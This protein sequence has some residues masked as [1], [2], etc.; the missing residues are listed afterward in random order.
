MLG[1]I[2]LHYDYFSVDTDIMQGVMRVLGS[3]D[4]K[5][6][7]DPYFIFAFAGSEVGLLVNYYLWHNLACN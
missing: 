5:E 6:L 4:K 1:I 2:W 3:D 7:V